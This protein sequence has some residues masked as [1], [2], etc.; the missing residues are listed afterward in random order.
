MRT[1]PAARAGD[2]T[3]I[4]KVCIDMYAPNSMSHWFARCPINYI[5]H[6]RAS[7][8]PTYGGDGDGCDSDKQPF[9][10]QQAL[11]EIH[12]LLF[13]I[14]ISRV[15][16]IV[17]LVYASHTKLGKWAEDLRT[18][19]EMR[20]L[21]I[22]GIARGAPKQP[23]ADADADADAARDAPEGDAR[24]PRTPRKTF[25][26]RPADAGDRGGAAGGED[27]RGQDP[28]SDSPEGA[29]AR[30]A[31]AG[32][33]AD[34]SERS[35]IESRRSSMASTASHNSSETSPRSSSLR[36]SSLLRSSGRRLRRHNSG[37]SVAVEH[38][39][40]W[41]RINNLQMRRLSQ[42]AI[43]VP[44]AAAGAGGEPPV[45]GRRSAMRAAREV[46]IIAAKAEI[47]AIQDVDRGRH[48]EAA[49][50]PGADAPPP[51]RFSVQESTI[52]ESSDYLDAAE[53]SAVRG[54]SESTASTA[55]PPAGREDGKGPAT[56]QAAIRQRGDTLDEVVSS[57]FSESS[58]RA[59][60]A[61]QQTRE[62][63]KE[64]PIEKTV[65]HRFLCGLFPDVTRRLIIKRKTK[66]FMRQLM[67]EKELIESQRGGGAAGPPAA[68][69]A[70]A[71][72]DAD[73][74]GDAKRAGA[75]R[76]APAESS[77]G[78]LVPYIKGAVRHAYYS[79]H[80]QTLLFLRQFTHGV[81]RGDVD[82]ARK[83]F[84]RK[85]E[86]PCDFDFLTYT[87]DS[88]D[89]DLAEVMEVHWIEWT[90]GMLYLFGVGVDDVLALQFWI[91]LLGLLLISLVGLQIQSVMF[92]VAALR[93]DDEHTTD[94]H[95]WFGNPRNMLWML[96][97][98][99]SIFSFTLGTPGRTDPHRRSP[100]GRSLTTRARSA[101]SRRRRHQRSPTSSRGRRG[102]T[103]ATSTS[104]A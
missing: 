88:V 76:R 87:S 69:G 34:A 80:L 2:L 92:H 42:E 53:P 84:I 90:V 26:T 102:S 74:N 14:G 57:D 27:G 72:A 73:G 97:I 95:F 37:E 24:W 3:Q 30:E 18:F 25:E 78:L 101:P 61:R 64:A 62:R 59:A 19:R 21:D 82:E 7:L 104:G 51:P 9:A 44:P 13:L 70:G 31:E 52:R 40:S 98:S 89:E 32:P 100:F 15:L 11:H 38:E 20:T 71:G 50:A 4:T 33:A 56:P 86:L 75:A 66:I 35:Y 16:A 58:I 29:R 12:Y 41:L 79:L 63:T 49:A 55:P 6:N 68:A 81:T 47:A 39:Q 45:E 77:E 23:D 65:L 91:P 96:R 48:A 17:S 8:G 54:R 99:T 36:G 22:E 46:S 94:S 85:H 83:S 93:I 67:Q 28:A 5:G 1:I 103:R 60:I 43:A 10:S